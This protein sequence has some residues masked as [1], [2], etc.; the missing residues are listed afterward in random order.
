MFR[1]VA[2]CEILIC[3]QLARWDVVTR[4]QREIKGREK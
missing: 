4:E 1:S 2:A 3:T